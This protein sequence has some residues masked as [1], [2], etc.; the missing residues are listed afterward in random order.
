MKRYDNFIDGEW[1]AAQG[2]RANINPS[3]TN[4]IIGEFASAGGDHVRHA[5]A[6]ANAAF[7]GWAAFPV[8][9]RADIL[10]RASEALR[11]DSK[12]LGELLAREQGRPLVEAVGEVIRAAQI[13]SFFAG[14]VVRT[15]G[16]IYPSTRVGGEVYVTREPLGVIGMITPW[17]VPIA[18]PAWKIA[19]ALAY[20][21]CVVLKPAELVPASAWELTRILSEAGLPKGVLNLVMGSGREVGA[22][23]LESPDIQA[24][25]FTGSVQTGRQIAI[26]AVQTGKKVQTE[27]GGKNPLIILDDADLDIAVDCAIDGAFFWTG[28][29]CTASSRLVVTRGIHDAFVERM[30]K[31]MADLKIDNALKPGTEIGPVVDERQLEQNLRY[32]EIA[33]SD[34]GEVVGGQRLERDAPGF[35]MAPALVLNT[36]NAMRINREEVFG[37][38]ASVIKVS[39]YDEALH[40]ANDTEFGLSSGICTQSL[41]RS[42]HFRRHSKAG[43]VAVN[44]TTTGS[45]YHVAFGGRKGSSYGAREQGRYAIDFYTSIKTSYVRA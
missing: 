5:I 42:T 25:S 1:V 24:V 9:Q 6:A 23:L 35:Y 30:T 40:V 33:G 28:Q 36:N 8:Q 15:G 31:R 21:N 20:G 26:Q 13:F 43:T 37:P 14:E 41:S 45:E 38:V 18:I 17:N 39:D 27:M 19:P 22:A 7:P 3:N 34:G 12:R 10:L 11:N 32:V 44:L 16:E 29:R 2:T 4:D